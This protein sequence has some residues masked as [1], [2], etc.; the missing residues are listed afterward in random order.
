MFY[1]SDS[2]LQNNP[3]IQSECE[4]ILQDIVGPAEHCYGLE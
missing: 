4:N 2:I 3:H 1:R